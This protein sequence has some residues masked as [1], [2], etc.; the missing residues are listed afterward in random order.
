MNAIEGNWEW[1]NWCHW[2]N[3][4]NFRW[5]PG[6]WPRSPD[7][8][9]P[10]FGVFTPVSGSRWWST[11][12]SWNGCTFMTCQ[13]LLSRKRGARHGLHGQHAC[14]ALR[15]LCAPV[16]ESSKKVPCS[17]LSCNIQLPGCDNLTRACKSGKYESGASFRSKD[18]RNAIPG[19]PVD[20]MALRRDGMTCLQL[21]R[22][23]AVWSQVPLSFPPTQQVGTTQAMDPSPASPAS[24]MP[25]L[26]QIIPQATVERQALGTT[27]ADFL[28]RLGG[29]AGQ[30]GQ[31]TPISAVG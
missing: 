17:Y 28:L 10:L 24:S 22:S 11:F 27:W 15:P 30:A 5:P 12:Q 31:P 25:V 29:Q 18:L 19:L 3:S 14:Y 16:F 1:W 6:S 7:S 2:Q 4:W 8:N 13:S 21:W 20:V 23:Q 26:G 9:T